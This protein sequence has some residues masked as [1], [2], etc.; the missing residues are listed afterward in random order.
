MKT[1]HA[2][3]WVLPS[4]LRLAFSLPLPL[5]L[6][7]R[8]AQLGQISMWHAIGK[9]CAELKKLW[10]PHLTQAAAQ[11]RKTRILISIHLELMPATAIC[12]ILT[13][14]RNAES[15]DG[16]NNKWVVYLLAE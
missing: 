5:R 3:K 12:S 2:C 1:P 7:L 15:S 16:R 14:H 9:L 10:G 4:G 6:G 11:L 8:R 13:Q